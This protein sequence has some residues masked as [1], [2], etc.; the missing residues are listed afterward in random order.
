[1]LLA[2]SCPHDHFSINGL[3]ARIVVWPVDLP[4]HLCVLEDAAMD[5]RIAICR[6]WVLRVVADIGRRLALVGQSKC[7]ELRA[8]LAIM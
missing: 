4:C 6:G 8:R 2:P 5:V 7:L 1:M 3:S